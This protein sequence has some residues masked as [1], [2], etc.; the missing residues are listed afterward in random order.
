ME[1]LPSS[2]FWQDWFLGET[3][4]FMGAKVQAFHRFMCPQTPE[5]LGM[6]GADA[7]RYYRCELSLGCIEFCY[8]LG[9]LPSSPEAGLM[10]KT[11]SE[12][13]L[14]NCFRSLRHINIYFIYSLCHGSPPV[15][16]GW[17]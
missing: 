1:Q 15:L 16:G 14:G 5:V 3:V 13:L 2:S 7:E 4:S 8:V 12:I 11:A 10:L 9:K 17:L 6:Q